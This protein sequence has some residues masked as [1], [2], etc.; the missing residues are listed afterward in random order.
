[1]MLTIMYVIMTGQSIYVGLVG[2]NGSG[3][4]EACRY[5]ETLGF[6]TFS[7]SDI[8]RQEVKNRSLSMDRNSLIETANALKIQYGQDYLA[9]QVLKAASEKGAE[10]IVF[11]SIRN[12]DEIQFLKTHGTH[13]LGI[14]APIEK[15]YERI[16]KRKLER[17]QIDFETFKVHC[18]REMSGKSSGQHI[19]KALR[20]CALVINNIGELTALHHQIDQFLE[21]TFGAT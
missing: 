19:E 3:K 5:L 11:D 20:K 16:Q 15:R 9:E 10:K 12:L 1:M 18:I 17:D 7:L 8:V 4:S 21:N 14:D 6:E 13:F 2:S